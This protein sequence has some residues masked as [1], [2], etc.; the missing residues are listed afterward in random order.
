MRVLLR[1]SILSAAFALVSAIGMPALAADADERALEPVDTQRIIATQSDNGWWDA[2]DG[3]KG[4]L[5]SGG[6][7]PFVG[8]G[9][10]SGG[11]GA[12]VPEPGTMALLGK[13]LAA[14]GVAR[15]RRKAGA[16]AE[17]NA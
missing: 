6:D 17:K 16:E 15:R 14:L 7:N 2:D 4:H 11:G 12:V 5:G 9:G 3:G 8:G 1:G 13:G 10:G